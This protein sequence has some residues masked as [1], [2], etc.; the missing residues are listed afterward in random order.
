MALNEKNN[1]NKFSWRR[2]YEF[3]MIFKSS[4]RTQI[5]IYTAITLLVYLCM[6]PV[7]K[8]T[9]DADLGIFSI[10]SIIFSYTI[11]M[12]PLAFARRDDSIIAQ[13]PVKT[14]EKFAFYLVY[15][16]LF[17]P[18]LVEVIWYG[19]NYGIGLFYNEGNIDCMARS[20]L[21]TQYSITLSSSEIFFTIINSFLQYC[22]I[23]A[24]T[25]YIII[26]SRQHRVIKGILSPIAIT[27]ILGLISGISGIIMAIYGTFN[28]TFKE[29]DDAY[30]IAHLV[31]N[32]SYLSLIID[33]FAIVYTLIICRCLY[34]HIH[35]CQ[36]S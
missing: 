25:L 23:I 11:Y 5:I 2:A 27:F 10:L 24:T 22:A 31:T 14:S 9:S 33:T 34:R 7:R 36:I 17:I 6:L 19:L 8:I 15:S 1:I 32:L 29:P 28:G 4:I 26:R 30:F 12:G 35:K 13:M 20:F 21:K 16:L 3:G 18:L